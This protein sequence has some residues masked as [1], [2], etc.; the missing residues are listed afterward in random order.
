MSNFS[1]V[2]LAA[3]VDE[4]ARHKQSHDRNCDGLVGVELITDELNGDL[5]AVY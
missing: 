1:C 4:H 5:K 2:K 3:Q